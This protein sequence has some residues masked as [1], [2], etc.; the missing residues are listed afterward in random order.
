MKK[1][2]LFFSLIL[3]AIFAFCETRNIVPR[4]PGE[5]SI[6]TSEKP[7]G[8]GWFDD[9]H[10]D[11]NSIFSNLEG[12][13]GVVV[14]T[15]ESGASVG[16]VQPSDQSNTNQ[17]LK[18]TTNGPTWDS[19]SIEGSQLGF[20]NVNNL[21]P[22]QTVEIDG[23]VLGVYENTP[24]ENDVQTFEINESIANAFTVQQIEGP[25][26]FISSDDRY[27]GKF[28]SSIIGTDVQPG[29]SLVIN[30][31]YYPIVDIKVDGTG[32]K[33]VQLSK[34]ISANSTFIIDYITGIVFTDYGA[35]LS[36]ASNLGLTNLNQKFELDMKNSLIEGFCCSYDTRIRYYITGNGFICRSDD[37]GEHYYVINRHPNYDTYLIS[38]MS[39]D[40]SPDGSTI[41]VKF[42][43]N[44]N[45]GNTPYYSTDYGETLTQLPVS[46]YSTSCVCSGSNQWGSVTWVIGTRDG[47]PYISTN[48]LES[49]FQPTWSGLPTQIRGPVYVTPNLTKIAY[50]PAM[51]NSQRNTT[52]AD[53]ENE[54]LVNSRLYLRDGYYEM[55]KILKYDENNE[56]YICLYSTESLS[57]N[58]RG[59]YKGNAIALINDET[60][61]VQT[62][63]LIHSYIYNIINTVSNIFVNSSSGLDIFTINN[64]NI[65]DIS[66][67][68]IYD[69]LFKYNNIDGAQSFFDAIRISK[70]NT[71]FNIGNGTYD[72]G[73]RNFYKINDIFRY[74]FYQNSDSYSA[75]L[76]FTPFSIYKDN[77]L[78][79]R[80]YGFDNY[81]LYDSTIFGNLQ[82]GSYKDNLYHIID[83]QKQRFMSLTQSSSNRLYA[84]VND[85]Y[86]YNGVL[87]RSDDCGK[88]WYFPNGLPTH[89]YLQSIYVE[90]INGK[91][92]ILLTSRKL[93]KSV[94]YKQ[95]DE[96]WTMVKGSWHGNSDSDNS[97]NTKDL[98]V[99]LLNTNSI[100][101]SHVHVNGDG[102]L[103]VFNN[104]FNRNLKTKTYTFTH[105]EFFSSCNDSDITPTIYHSSARRYNANDWS[106]TNK[107]YRLA[108]LANN[109]LLPNSIAGGY[110]YIDAVSSNIVYC[111]IAEAS[112]KYNVF[113][114]KDAG[115]TWIN[116]TSNKAAFE[117]VNYLSDYPTIWGIDENRCYITVGNK[118]YYTEDS[119]ETWNHIS[120]IVYGTPRSIS[121]DHSNRQN[122]NDIYFTIWRSDNGPGLFVTHDQFQNVEP[123]DYHDG[124][125]GGNFLNYNVPYFGGLYSPE[126][127]PNIVYACKNSSTPIV[128]FDGGE[129]WDYVKN[130][131][132][133]IPF[134]TI[135][136]AS[137][138]ING[139]NDFIMM[140][141]VKNRYERLYPVNDNNTLGQIW[142]SEFDSEEP[143]RRHWTK[144][145]ISDKWGIEMP[146][147]SR[148]AFYDGHNIRMYN[149]LSIFYYN[150]NIVVSPMNIQTMISREGIPVSTW[151]SIESA[152]ISDK[153][154]SYLDSYIS[155]LF[156]FDDGESYRK[157]ENGEWVKIVYTENNSVYYRVGEET[158]AR[159]YNNDLPTA[160]SKAMEYEINRFTDVDIASMANTDWNLSGG[161]N[162]D[163]ESV[164]FSVSFIP[165]SNVKLGYNSPNINGISL[166]G[167]TRDN[168]FTRNMDNYQI[169]HT[170][171][172][173]N[174]T[175]TNST[176]IDVIIQYIRNTIQ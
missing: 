63:Y 60:Q 109:E 123:I 99:D 110:F 76:G 131:N 34:P 146:L 42:R 94:L 147:A 162:Q 4:G 166:L 151:N 16:L 96:P 112:G 56:I 41:I 8:D 17:V 134:P 61:Q 39:I 157:I 173:D 176:I 89:N 77:I 51:N 142:F 26:Q 159:V 83:G 68:T 104:L 80:F 50:S 66:Q 98:I 150:T 49:I 87:M 47:R 175:K 91:T 3:I 170:E 19:I 37:Y 122:T 33:S 163:T 36:S 29:D 74:L 152:I 137:F 114:T 120:D 84:I 12:T 174:V 93:R 101:S 2:G 133:E 148:G 72:N 172:G 7:W 165:P 73:T 116:I 118:A 45:E 103:Y 121:G 90:S 154:D 153:Y 158:Y 22:G 67:S 155:I 125:I 38:Y 5:G 70:D 108:N 111:S 31:R 11:G 127:K 25:T 167:V 28:N 15:T 136:D 106:Y 88:R 85:N 149:G 102:L 58:T 24:L 117:N 82:I 78:F 119:G 144:L 55:L 132:G 59:W 100:I 75:S 21:L 32:E 145:D 48:N 86:Y 10:V 129:T 40:C 126:D 6:G 20:T 35:E 79:T 128:S 138:I 23:R 140:I 43:R 169:N 171:Y 57:E 161:F 65:R 52:F 168:T 54:T 164:K 53:I 107:L 97:F 64:N 62:T 18:W 160:I 124:E 30:G 105:G 69:Y 81:A 115:E 141:Q 156:S 135:S 1:L 27:F 9:L 130:E 44:N 46:Y 143:N 113:E 71:I 92:N 139:R 14:E 95:G 13:N